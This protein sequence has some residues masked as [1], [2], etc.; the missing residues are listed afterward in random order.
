M[1][2]FKNKWIV[3]KIYKNNDNKISFDIFTYNY[4]VIKCFKN[5]TKKE[6]S[7]DIWYLINT[8]IN[9]KNEWKLNTI[10]NIKIIWEQNNLKNFEEINA[11][12][13]LLSFVYKKVWFNIANYETFEIIEDIIK[14]EN[15]N[16]DKIIL[17]KIKIMNLIWELDLN[18][19][20][21]TIKKILNFIDK[22]HFK[23]IKKL[24]WIDD[25]LRKKLID[26][27]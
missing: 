14:D 4:W 3:L 23:E 17:A 18:N 20:N 1:S 13:E 10:K 15:I 9:T 22:N 11:F 26:I 2:I 6:K 19:E 7:L 16:L 5:K 24:K 25:E 21:K 27:K 8:E 12:L